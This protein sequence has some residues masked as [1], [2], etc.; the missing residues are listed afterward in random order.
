M[1]MRWA[2]DVRGEDDDH[3]PTFYRDA[4]LSCDCWFRLFDIRRVVADDTA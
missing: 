1:P 4:D 2:R 3:V